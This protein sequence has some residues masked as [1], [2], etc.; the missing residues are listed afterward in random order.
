[1]DPLLKRTIAKIFTNAEYFVVN[2]KDD[3]DQDIQVR[4]YMIPAALFDELCANVDADVHAL[5][6]E[7]YENDDGQVEF[8]ETEEPSQ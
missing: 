1:M 7:L 5:A 2:T 4:G 8:G 3:D 6:E